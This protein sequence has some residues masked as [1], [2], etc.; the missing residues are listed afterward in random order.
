MR[1]IRQKQ[2]GVDKVSIG[3]SI[4]ANI[5]GRGLNFAPFGSDESFTLLAANG[6]LLNCSRLEN[7]ELFS[8]VMVGGLFE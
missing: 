4:S 6:D 3:G 1:A 7:K 8:L 2:T 5:H